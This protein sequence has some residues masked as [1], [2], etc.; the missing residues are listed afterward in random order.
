MSV[1]RQYPATAVTVY[2]STNGVHSLVI[3]NGNG[4]LRAE[5][6]VIDCTPGGWRTNSPEGYELVKRDFAALHGGKR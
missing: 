6:Q 4:R 3:G 2:D 1:H 5:C